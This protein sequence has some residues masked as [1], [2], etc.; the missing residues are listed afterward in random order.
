MT[1]SLSDGDNDNSEQD[2]ENVKRVP[3]LYF[4]EEAS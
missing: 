3:M 4:I 1:T 2:E